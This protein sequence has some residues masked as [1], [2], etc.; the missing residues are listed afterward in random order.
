MADRPLST[1]D[2]RK[3]LERFSKIADAPPAPPLLRGKKQLLLEAVLAGCNVKEAAQY[4]GY[5]YT[6]AT[7]IVKVDDRFK[8]ALERARD[9]RVRVAAAALDFLVP[10]AIRRLGD[11]IKDPLAS[12]C[13]VIAA[14]RQ[15]LDRGGMP[16]VERFLLED[17][18]GNEHEDEPT[19][20]LIARL[21]V[22]RGGRSA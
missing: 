8:V 18:T 1:D 13:D 16:K 21:E 3:I 10:L 22:I 6:H 2:A 7:R 15:I 4:S 19:E 12:D 11:I 5:S 14:A 9:E 20:A 17:G